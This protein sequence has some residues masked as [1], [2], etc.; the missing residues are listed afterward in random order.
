MAI[1]WMIDTAG[2]TAGLYGP[3]Q[4]SDQQS[5]RFLGTLPHSVVP[6]DILTPALEVAAVDAYGQAVATLEDVEVV[7]IRD[8]I[9]VV[10]SLDD[11]EVVT[12][13]DDLEVSLEAF[14]PSGPRI[15]P[16]GITG[17][18]T[19]I[20]TKGKTE[21]SAAS[22]HAPPGS[23]AVVRAVLLEHELSTPSLLI[24]V[25][26]C[27]PG[28]ELGAGGLS[29]DRCLPGFFSDSG[30]GRCAY[31]DRGAICPGGNALRVL[32]GFYIEILSPLR[33]KPCP[34]A[35]ACLGGG[36][37]AA[38]A[39]GF[40]GK[41]CGKCADDRSYCMG[42]CSAWCFPIVLV[43]MTTIVGGV[44]LLYVVIRW[45]RE[46]EQTLLR[47]IVAG[48]RKSKLYRRKF[49]VGGD[50]DDEEESLYESAQP[51]AA[52]FPEAD[53]EAREAGWARGDSDNGLDVLKGM[54]GGVRG[55]AALDT[56]ED[57]EVE[58]AEVGGPSPAGE[59]DEVTL[60]APRDREEQGRAGGRYSRVVGRTNTGSLSPPPPDDP[61]DSPQGSL[62]PPPD[63]PPDSPQGSLSPPPP[64]DPNDYPQVLELRP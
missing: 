53:E 46:G 43:V 6:G 15:S 60:L 52:F 44:S 31:C 9:E 4:A 26:L 34:I 8:E 16:G 37:D 49:K 48:S 64:D 36:S 24:E 7:T 51:L 58:M 47:N 3:D 5:L 28:Q 63:D 33:V 32:P 18:S 59:G 11:L 17:D 39:Q 12:T 19:S 25:R 13:L 41:D 57:L 10:T 42:K 1:I 29:C 56:G 45:G 35:E 14:L 23:E 54:G 22:L 20:L 55:A 40:A 38:C 2:N 50:P 61:P 21:F 27:E 30:G 62:S